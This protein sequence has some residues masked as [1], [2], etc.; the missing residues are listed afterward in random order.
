MATKHVFMAY[1][2]EKGK[3]TEIPIFDKKPLTNNP[4]GKVRNFRLF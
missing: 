1:F 3:K 4:F 2:A